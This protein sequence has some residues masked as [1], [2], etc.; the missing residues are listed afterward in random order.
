MHGNLME[1]AGGC[2][3]AKKVDDISAVTQKLTEGAADVRNVNG[4]F[5]ARSKV[6]VSLQKVPR[7]H[8]KWTGYPADALQ[9]DGRYC[10][11]TES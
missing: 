5:R 10:R 8:E 7:M 4:R 11:C 3:E 2:V 1:V 9:L 6:N